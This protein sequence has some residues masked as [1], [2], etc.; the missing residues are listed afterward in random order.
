MEPLAF[1][2]GMF[3][4]G[5]YVWVRLESVLNQAH[6]TTDEAIR[7]AQDALDELKKMAGK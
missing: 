6:K 3:V 7:V 5:G 2:I 4:G 1:V